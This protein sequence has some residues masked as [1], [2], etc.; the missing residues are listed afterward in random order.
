MYY[1]KFD[2]DWL[3]YFDKLDNT[4]RDRV[5]KKIKKILLSPYKRHLK[6]DARFFVDEIG[7]DRIAY[8]IFEV[9]KEVRFYFVG[10]HKDYE[11]WY[12][13]FF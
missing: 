2:E 13:Q 11:K 9:E 5:S 6:K 1:S 8:R 3:N 10:K 12:R 4:A 7:Q